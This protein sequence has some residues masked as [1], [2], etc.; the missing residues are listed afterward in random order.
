MALESARPIQVFGI[1]YYGVALLITVPLFFLGYLWLFI[2][3][4]VRESRIG[5]RVPVEL[6]LWF[7]I[8][9]LLLFLAGVI[10][11]T[12]TYQDGPFWLLGGLGLALLGILGCAIPFG[13][14]FVRRSRDGSNM[15][16]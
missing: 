6:V 2:A 12:V 9:S 10:V 3:I 11:S 15:A 1:I 14:Q 16:E 5:G 7:C 13:G 8:L 4:A